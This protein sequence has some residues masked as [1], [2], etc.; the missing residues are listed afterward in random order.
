MHRPSQD[1]KKVALQYCLMSATIAEIVHVLSCELT[2]TVYRIPALMV[3][4]FSLPHDL[5]IHKFLITMRHLQAHAKASSIILGILLMLWI[6]LQ[7]TNHQHVI[8]RSENDSS[9]IHFLM[10][11]DLKKHVQMT[12]VNIHQNLQ[13]HSALL[14]ESIPSE[15]MRYMS[16]S[17]PSKYEKKWYVFL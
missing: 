2:Q 6:D 17:H 8:S 14:G 16:K 10:P 5:C 15:D 12:W 4:G 11:E 3:S 7:V 1:V 13:T 9:P